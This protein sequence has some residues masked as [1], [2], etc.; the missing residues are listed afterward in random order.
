MSCSFI[1]IWNVLV[2]V[3]G[4]E[5]DICDNQDPDDWLLCYFRYFCFFALGAFKIFSS[6][7]FENP[8][9]LSTVIILLLKNIST[10]PFVQLCSIL[11]ATN[12]LISFLSFCLSSIC[13]SARDW[14]QGLKHGMQ[15]Y[16]WAKFQPL[17]R[18]LTRH[19]IWY[20]ATFTVYNV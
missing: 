11:D 14:T 1:S 17:L 2:C 12:I 13:C 18:F 9:L 5:S 4:V 10:Y 8:Q 20:L 6:K 16:R 15:T 19:S 3:Y 7:C